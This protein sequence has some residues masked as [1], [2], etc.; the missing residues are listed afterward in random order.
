MPIIRHIKPQTGS[1]LIEVLIATIVVGVILTGV[2]GALTS[3]LKNSS[4][5]Q[6]RQVATRLAQE[7]LE[8]FAQHRAVSSWTGFAGTPG[9]SGANYFCFNN[10]YDAVSDITGSAVA[11]VTTCTP[12]TVTG[13][14]TQFWRGVN[15]SVDSP[16]KVEVSAKVIWSDG[17]SERSTEL[18]QAFF[19]Y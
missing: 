7:A 2:V 1:T 13:V 12:L 15:V 8:V 14:P 4:E 6:N 16:T 5:A 19:R 9:D 17:S 10:A 11:S 3:S 18:T